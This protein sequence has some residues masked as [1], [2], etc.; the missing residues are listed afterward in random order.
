MFSEYE[1]DSIKSEYITIHNEKMK[2]H[3]KIS[4]LSLIGLVGI[5]AGLYALRLNVNDPFDFL[6][7]LYGGIGFFALF[8]YV[9]FSF[10]TGSSKAFYEYVVREVIDKIN[11]DYELE[12][13]YS[14]DKK[15]KFSH[16][17]RGGLF[18]RHCR[19]TVRMK[20]K[21]KSIEGREFELYELSLIT[22]GGNSQQTHLNGIYIVLGN[23]TKV[24]KQIRT[25]GRPHLKGTE[26]LKVESDYEYKVYVK[27]GMFEKDYNIDYKDVFSRVMRDIEKQKVYLSVIEGETHFA[28]H[29]FKLYKY[30]KLS[31]DNLNIVYDKIKWLIELVDTLKIDEF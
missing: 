12:V 19:S 16:N 22:G 6:I 11:L 29:P 15:T 14:T 24:V 2:K 27:E 3:K 31:I 23:Q 13:M 7:P 26:Y 20:I 25:H 10:G 18:S 4:V 1:F 9:L 17:L 28:L 8:I 30:R 5:I 21:G